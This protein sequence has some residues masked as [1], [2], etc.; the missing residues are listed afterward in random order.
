[1]KRNFLIIFTVLALTFAGTNAFADRRGNNGQQGQIQ[2]QQQQQQQQNN[3]DITGADAAAKV[4]G[5]TASITQ[6]NE[7]A[8]LSQGRGFAIPGEMVFPGTPGYFGEATPGHRF[9]P[10]NKLL[11]FTTMWDAKKAANMLNGRTGNKDVQIRDLYAKYDTPAA[12]IVYCSIASPE[13]LGATAIDQM[14][15][16]TVAAE[17]RKSI[18][19]DVLA[20][21]I[22]AASERGAN[23]ILFMAEGVNREVD[24]Q[25]FGIGFNFTKA[26]LAGGDNDT[27][28]VGSGGLGYSRGWAGYIDY[29]WMQFTFLK[30]E[31]IDGLPVVNVQAAVEVEKA[32]LAAAA[33]DALAGRP[34]TK[35]VNY[36]EYTQGQTSGVVIN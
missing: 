21:A 3:A 14:S 15:I 18:S 32:P 26:T 17:N 22:V 20:T 33:D 25:G 5:V 36:Q 27:S 23:F 28:N 19:A 31:G 30:V 16:G 8:D 7:A 1:M 2:G 9:I 24:A 35:P 29:P 34:N 10:L 6:H 13:D 11:R 4:E 12:D